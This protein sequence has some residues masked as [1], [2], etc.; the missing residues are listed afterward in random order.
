M[1][2]FYKHILFLL[3][4][5]ASLALN[6]NEI[7]PIDSLTRLLKKVKQDTTKLRLLYVLSNECDEEDI[8]K[9]AKP[10]VELADAIISNS[11]NLSVEAKKN[12]L[13][14]KAL[15]L[16]N[17]GFVYQA[18]GDY[19]NA[20]DHYSKSLK[21]QEEIS[22]K[23]DIALS[24]NNLAVAWQSQGNFAKALN[25]YKKSIAIQQEIGDKEG[26]A[27]SLGNLG[28]IYHDIGDPAKALDCYFEALKLEDE[29]G[30]KPGWPLH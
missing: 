1:K 2:V 9:Y 16:G 11:K 12:V 24:F 28:L 30:E 27:N 21:I 6:A 3:I 23:H 15:C 25:Y 5:S 10:G 29:I 13:K 7:E 17:I 22:D 20:L 18:T 8:L 4:F 19:E 14:F 26:K